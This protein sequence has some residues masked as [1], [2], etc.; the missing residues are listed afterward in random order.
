MLNKDKLIYIDFSNYEVVKAL[1]LCRRELE[2]K[3]DSTNFGINAS[4]GQTLTLEEIVCI[5]ASLD[6]LIEKCKFNNKRLELLSLLFKGNSIVDVKEY[7]PRGTRGTRKL[8]DSIIKDIN[9]M[10][11]SVSEIGGE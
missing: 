9:D 3:I 7:I 10:S 2:D 6:S 8:L 1:I 11:K 5:Y 4:Y